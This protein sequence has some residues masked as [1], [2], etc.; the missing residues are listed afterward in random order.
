MRGCPKRDDDRVANAVRI[1][2]HVQIAEADHGE[3]LFLKQRRSAFVA[4]LIAVGVAVNFDD[5]FRGSSDKVGYGAAD[6]VLADELNA[7]KLAIAKKPP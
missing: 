4:R 3:T 7:T 2:H 6:D 5:E 1:G